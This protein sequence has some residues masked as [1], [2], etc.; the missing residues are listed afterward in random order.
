[1]GSM[2]VLMRPVRT[3]YGG[4][5]MFGPYITRFPTCPL[6]II[7]FL[8]GDPHMAG[9]RGQKFDFTGK[10]GGWYAVVSDLPYMHLNMRVTS[11]VPSVLEITYIT[12]ISIVA[13][14][15]NGLDHTIVISVV[16]PHNLESPCSAETSPCLAEGALN[17]VV[18]GEE[19]MISPGEVTV[20]PGV[21]IA[22]VNLPG[23][24]RSFGFEKY[25]ERKKL[26]RL[27]HPDRRL[28]STTTMQDM[29]AGSSRTPRRPI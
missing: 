14:D 28:I 13:M 3:S 9:F 12:G 19:V 23:S 11:P 8:L 22:A 27:V 1:M 29:S 25:W 18:D 16:H 20:A 4:F 6:P 26:E 24:C 21:A 15:T 10:D 2:W 7:P 5:Y 17:V